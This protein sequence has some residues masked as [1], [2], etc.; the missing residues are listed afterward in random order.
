MK[1]DACLD[2]LSL[3]T[4]ALETAEMGVWQYDVIQD[5][6]SFDAGIMKLYEVNDCSELHTM[7][8]WI[9][10]LHLDDQKKAAHLIDRA[11]KSDYDIDHQLRIKVKSDKPNVDKL[12]FIRVKAKR[13][14]NAEGRVVR[15]LGINWDMTVEVQ[16]LKEKRI[17][18]QNFKL[19]LSLVD[20]SE[21]IFGFADS[22]GIPLYVN[23]AGLE[24]YGIQINSVGKYFSEYLL[25]EDKKF[26]EAVVIPVLLHGKNWE[27][28]LRL[29]SPKKNEVIPFWVRFFTVKAQEVNSDVFYCCLA[30]DLTKMKS[31]QNLL[32][33]QTKLATLG[34]VTSGIAHE[35]NNPL[36]IIVGK[37]SLLKQKLVNKDIEP[38]KCEAYLTSIEQNAER[39]TKI[40]RSLNSFSRNSINDPMQKVSILKIIDDAF[41]ILKEKFKND[42]IDFTILIDEKMNYEN[43]IEARESEILQ[44]LINIL[45]N[46]YDAVVAQKN[47]W[48]KLNISEK[49][50]HYEIKIID[51]GLGISPDIV[52]HINEPF[53]T[54]KPTGQGTGLGLS[55]SADIIKSH[56]GSLELDKAAKETTF[57]IRLNKI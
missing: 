53:F 36:S 10:R 51:S 27:G 2:L 20:S 17:F 57:I 12:K 31:I 21:D 48:I 8:D 28:E 40:I 11:I 3:Y 44:V 33:Q 34:K 6:L 37:T 16:R 35:V 46:S 39:I 30:S 18:D 52:D 19:M 55:L 23:K 32:L 24:T 9:S 15:L 54:T 29:I 22:M 49:A 50:N 5:A 1:L 7:Q 4:E 42:E 56:A 45:N 14:K 43:K 26:V 13:I 38:T 41:E 47:K 25:A